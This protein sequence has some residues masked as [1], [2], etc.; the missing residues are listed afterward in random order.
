MAKIE[1][2]INGPLRGSI[3]NITAS[4]WNGIRYIKSKPSQVK[5]PNTPAQKKQRGSFKLVTKSLAPLKPFINH[6]FKDAVRM[7]P[8]NRAVQF[9]MK[10]AVRYDEEREE[11]MIH[12]PSVRMGE[13][14][15]PSADDVT[16]VLN[17]DSNAPELTL[18]WNPDIA[19]NSARSTDELFILVYFKGAR[20]ALYSI[21]DARRSDALFVLP[22]PSGRLLD[23]SNGPVH[24]FAGFSRP[25]NSDRSVASFIPTNLI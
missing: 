25:D 10:H 1:D 20:H 7:T 24:V 6:G 21:G 19:T 5:N 13:G 22:I 18:T 14:D 2:G 8:M 4:S 17:R 11:L 23:E 9:T 12:W 15:L 16:A 3:G